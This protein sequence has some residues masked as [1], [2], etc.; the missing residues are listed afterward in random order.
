MDD[1]VHPIPL[2]CSSSTDRISAFVNSVYGAVPQG[3]GA[4]LV[5]AAAPQ[6][7]M[8]TGVRY[9]IKLQP[10]TCQYYLTFSGSINGTRL[11]IENTAVTT[12]C[13]NGLLS[14][15]TITLLNVSRLSVDYT[16][17]SGAISDCLAVGHFE[18]DFSDI[19]VSEIPVEEDPTI[20]NGGPS[21]E[22]PTET[23]EER[24]E[25][26]PTRVLRVAG[27]NNEVVASGRG[28]FVDNKGGAAEILVPVLL[29]SIIALFGLFF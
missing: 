15:S 25:E 28:P 4:S 27:D 21:I 6:G 7:K 20:D 18:F 23:L 8:I 17:A 19:P 16:D 26:F 13:V 29:S 3:E 5:N 9:L 11:S 14:S 24:R 1:F 10:E 2:T 22:E 12:G